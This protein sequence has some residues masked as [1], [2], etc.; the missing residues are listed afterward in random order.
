VG[1][2]ASHCFDKE[3]RGV[4]KSWSVDLDW[5]PNYLGTLNNNLILLDK[6]NN[7][8]VEL[9]SQSGKE[10]NTFPLLWDSRQSVINNNHVILQSDSKLYVITI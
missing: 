6:Y 10:K 3:G 9:D 7:I 4:K 8:I 5:A 2:I 1:N